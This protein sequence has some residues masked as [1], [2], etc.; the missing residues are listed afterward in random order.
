MTDKPPVYQLKIV[1]KDSK[2]PIWRRLL[3]SSNTTFWELH[4]AIQDSFGWEDYHLHEFFIGSAWDRNAVRINIPNPEDDIFDEEKEPLDESKTLLHEYLNEQQPEITYVYDFGDNW[5]HQIILEKILPFD[6]NTVYPQVIAGKRACP[7]EDSGGIGGYEE[8]IEI[9]K[10]KNHEKHQEIAEWVEVDN[11]EQLDLE[12]FDPDDVIFRNPATELR[13][14][15]QAIE[16]K[17]S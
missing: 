8:K 15:Q 3:L 13:R 10:D 16:R 9:L 5:E 11:F 12:S 1:I 17:F 14:V 6:L 7:W 4:I 2:P